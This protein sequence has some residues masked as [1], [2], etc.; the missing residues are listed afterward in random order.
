MKMIISSIRNT[1][2]STLR[3]RVKMKRKFMITTTQERYM[4]SR[5]K[6]NGFRRNKRKW[7]RN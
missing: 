5:N 4:F 6:R 7:P 2:L 3:R 1:P